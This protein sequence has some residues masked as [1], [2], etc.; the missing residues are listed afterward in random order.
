MHIV[1]IGNGV[2]GIT[3]ARHIRKLSPASRTGG[4]HKITVVSGETDHFF[5][6]TALM[7]I[8]MGHMRFE[9]TKPYEDWF[10]EKNRIELVRGHVKIV[11]TE[12]RRLLFEDGKTLTFDQLLIATGSKSNKFGWPGQDLEGVQGLYH[13]QDLESMELHSAGLRR[14][15]IVGGGLIGIEMAEMFHSRHIPV[16]F[17]VREKNFWD[18][19]LPLEEAQMINRHILENGIDLRLETEL[20]EILPDTNGK[21]RA[22]VTNKGETIECGFVGLT[23]GVSPNVDFLKDSGIELGRGILVDDY[24][25]TNIPGIFAAGDCVQ[26][27]NPQPGRRP[28]EAVWYTGRMMGETAAYNIVNSRQSAVGSQGRSIPYDPGTWFNSAKFFDIEYQ[29]YG[30]V[31]ANP[32]ENHASLYWEHPDGRHS[33]RLIYDRKTGSILGF[34]LMGVRYRHEVC[35]KWLRMGTHIE[36]VLQN[37]GIANFDPEFYKQYEADLLALYNRQSGRNLTLKK[38]RGLAGAMAFLR[39]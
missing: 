30:T 5:S 29:V 21:A 16:T 32:P 38:R 7:Y 36:E 17:L 26:L 15:V 4:D 1:I 27:R 8:Y 35:E 37:L 23:V 2:A 34:N 19:V 3:A 25:E 28:I 33:I 11:E 22:V 31:L 14:A 20:K 12:S 24:L 9:D 10:W 18:P 6:R 39:A 13:Y